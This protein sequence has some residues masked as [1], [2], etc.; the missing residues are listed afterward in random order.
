MDGD[1][2]VR[3]AGDDDYFSIEVWNVLCGIVCCLQRHVQMLYLGTGS[4]T[5]EYI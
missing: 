4:R 1:V 5:T 3:T 2:R